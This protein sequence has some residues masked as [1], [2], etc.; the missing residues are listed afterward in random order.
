MVIGSPRESQPHE[1]RVGLTPFLANRLVE[2]GHT[3][4]IEAGAGGAAPFSDGAD[5]G[6]GAQSG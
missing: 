4:L 6:A 3:V 5:H 2:L 1:H